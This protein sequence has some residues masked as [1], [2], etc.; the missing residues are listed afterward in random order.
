[1]LQAIQL[2][3]TQP[4]EDGTLIE[5][6]KLDQL[7]ARLVTGAPDYLAVIDTHQN[8][9]DPIRNYGILNPGLYAPLDRERA[10]LERAYAAHL[11]TDQERAELLAT[12]DEQGKRSLVRR[13]FETCPTAAVYSVH[14]VYLGSDQ[15]EPY[16]SATFRALGAEQWVEHATGAGRSGYQSWWRVNGRTSDARIVMTPK[17]AP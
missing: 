12:L 10:D 2:A 14:R 3:R 9:N 17:P 4:T 7:R 13:W 15:Y 16:A 11:I 1:K 5:S 8:G 6:E